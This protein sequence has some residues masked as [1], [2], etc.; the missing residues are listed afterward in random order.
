MTS[1]S[2]LLLKKPGFLCMTPAKDEEIK[3][4]EDELQLKFSNEYGEYL[5]NYGVATF[6]G[7]ELTG[8]TKSSRLNVIAVTRKEREKTPFVPNSCYVVE[9]TNIDGIVIWQ[10]SSGEV[11]QTQSG[12]S[13][14]KIL[15]KS[16]YEYIEACK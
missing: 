15:Y 6:Q 1:L 11:F 12:C 3:R 9:D 13:E 8:L 7:H 2:Q 5:L 4:A 10:M 14:T 16:L